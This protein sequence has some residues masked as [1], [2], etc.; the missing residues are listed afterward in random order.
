[1]FNTFFDK[2]RPLLDPVGLPRDVLNS[3][4]EIEDH[5]ALLAKP[6]T[7]RLIQADPN[8]IPAPDDREG[9]FGE[10]HLEYWLSGLSDYQKVA[11]YLG[12]ASGPK[13]YFD[14]GGSTGRVARHA[15]QSGIESWLCDINVN[16]IDWLDKHYTGNIRSFQNRALPVLPFEDNYLS[17]VSAFSVFTHLDTD[18][19][20]WILEL[21]RVL[22]PGGILYAT[23]LDEGV[24]Q[25]LSQPGWEW[26]KATMS[27][28][29]NDEEFGNLCS[30]PLP[31]DRFVWSYS[32]VET[33]NINIFLTRAYVR[34]KW[35]AFFDVVD[36][37]PHGHYYQTAVVLRKR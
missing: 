26:L 12:A 32:D 18:A 16:W 6:E 10:R 31:G 3:D 20:Q 4:V 17:L 36:I 34:K 33:Y 14:M 11:A 23:I 19:T 9:Y 30:Q 37:I 8:V 15:D 7:Q 13:R 2:R 5:K 1:M 28:G 29:N 22:Q 24:W 35:G 25:L 21:R 27:R